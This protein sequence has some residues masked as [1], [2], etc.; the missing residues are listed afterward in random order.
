M[1]MKIILASDNSFVWAHGYDATGLTR[2][3]LRI[4]YVTTAA[5][6]AHDPAYV[7]ETRQA[8]SAAGLSFEEI[9]V[10]GKSEDELRAFFRDKNVIQVKG[11]NTFYLLK[12]IR[13]SGFAAVL[14]EELTAG[15][16][17]IGT[18]AG[19]YIMCPTIEVAAWNPNNRERFGVTDFTALNYVPYVLK[20]HYRDEDEATIAEK[21]KTLKYPL[22]RLRDGEGII[23]DDA[24]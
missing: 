21:A 18:S 20:A 5:N 12:A 2:D 23:N 9:D 4:G 3:Q 22:R 16:A 17:Y 7:D 19:V 8:M 15:K 24:I 1:T 11:G 14:R 13:A 6:T 10:L